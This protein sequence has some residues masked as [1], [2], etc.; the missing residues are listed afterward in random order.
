MARSGTCLRR[1]CTESM[2]TCITQIMAVEIGLRRET[3]PFP[4]LT[5]RLPGMVLLQCWL[6]LS[7]RLFRGTTA[8]SG[9]APETTDGALISF[10]QH[11]RRAGQS[12]VCCHCRS[13]GDSARPPSERPINRRTRPSFRGRCLGIAQRLGQICRA[14]QAGGGATCKIAKPRPYPLRMGSHQGRQQHDK[15]GC[16][17]FI[18]RC[19]GGPNITVALAAGRLH[20]RPADKGRSAHSIRRSIETYRGS[21]GANQRA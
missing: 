7:L 13:D 10:E 18:L 15:S 3:K 14:V 21:A 8:R 19:V 11:S 6:R 12:S 1:F 20:A 17:V 2:H 16:D 4:E 9:Q 5:D